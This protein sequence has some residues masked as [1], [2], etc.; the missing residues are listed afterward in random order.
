[1]A[2]APLQGDRIFLRPPRAS[3]YANW[4]ALR[5]A[6]RAFLVPYEPQWAPDELTRD[7]FRRRLRAYQ[8]SRRNGTGAPFFLFKHD[9]TLVGGINCNG[10]ARG[11]AQSCHIGY[12]VGI[13]F[14][15]QGYTREALRLLLTYGFEELGLH[16]IEANCLP[17]NAPSVGLLRGVGF[18]LEGLS[19]AY[20]MINGVWEDHLRFAMVR[21]DP[22]L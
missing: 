9:G 14:A 17:R 1:M 8:E 7:G 19:R 11:V 22:I 6:S 15:R 16:R 20:L 3:D 2:I 18:R 13:E 10:I 21:G 5:Q 12:W 4:A